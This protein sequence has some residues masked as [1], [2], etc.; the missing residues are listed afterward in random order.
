MPRLKV[1][2]N[3]DSAREQVST[4]SERQPQDVIDSFFSPNAD[5]ATPET[6]EQ[7][8][9][10]SEGNDSW[11]MDAVT[12]AA[13]NTINEIARD[14]KQRVDT[15][16]P[17]GAAEQHRSIDALTDAVVAELSAIDASVSAIEVWD[18]IDQAKQ[19]KTPEQKQ[20]AKDL[21]EELD[22]WLENE[23]ASSG[24]RKSDT[25]PLDEMRQ[26]IKKQMNALK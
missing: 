14:A 10:M 18:A 22:D 25:S 9:E 21:L 1:E 3:T 20:E 6:V 26:S 15:L 11:I 8:L 7:L 23:I 5:S 4:S 2:K 17:D 24:K 13:E 12:A 19:A 16:D